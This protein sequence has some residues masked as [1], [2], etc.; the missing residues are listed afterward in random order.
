VTEAERWSE[1]K[2]A[3]VSREQGLRLALEAT[4]KVL[5][6]VIRHECDLEDT[7]RI[8][9][10]PGRV[11]SF[12][13]SRAK[14]ERK[15]QAGSVPPVPGSLDDMLSTMQDVLGTRI[16]CKTLRDVD[17]V[18][19]AI[20]AAV[21]AG[22]VELISDF[23]DFNRE[24]KPSGYRALH[25][26][27]VVD[28]PSYPKPIQI[29]CEV[30]VRTLLQ[31]AW[32]ELTH[33]N[34]Y[35][36]GTVGVPEMF[37]TLSR[38]LAGMLKEVDELA[39]TAAHEIDRHVSDQL[40]SQVGDS[41]DVAAP[42]EAAGSDP[43]RQTAGGPPTGARTAATAVNV[44][45]DI[46]LFRLND[47]SSALLT[48]AELVQALPAQEVTDLRD[49]LGEGDA[50]TVETLDPVG[51][52]GRIRL[53]PADPTE[54]SRKPTHDAHPRRSNLTPDGRRV[55]ISDLLIA[56]LLRRGD[57]LVWVR[58]YLGTRYEVVVGAHGALDLPDGRACNSPSAAAIKV[59]GGGSF[60]GWFAWRV[61]RLG[62]ITLH[63]LRRRYLKQ[64][65]QPQ[66]QA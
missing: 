20:D 66:D 3:Y 17:L 25:V 38:H 50:L 45:E 49:F 57:T 36:P 13:R 54:I 37:S 23:E 35:K 43:A 1:L 19:E 62:D 47:G 63:E 16:T 56:G 34:V 11:K 41:D 7:D 44:L 46:A 4:V 53:R 30:Q 28:V 15:A 9:V 65:E 52:G 39:L 61:P 21:K 55:T 32:G 10:E 6:D 14:W 18:R 40:A 42:I 2:D 33:E 60:D 8:R 27:V 48:R 5:G 12:P 26:T 24:P 31:H 51:E 22:S 64:Q 29:P 59:A 58:P